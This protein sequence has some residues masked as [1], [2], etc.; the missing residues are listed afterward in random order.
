MHQQI[1][2]SANLMTLYKFLSLLGFICHSPFCMLYTIR[3]QPREA[4]LKQICLGNILPRVL[5]N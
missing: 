1:K 5:I 4:K 2:K 3:T